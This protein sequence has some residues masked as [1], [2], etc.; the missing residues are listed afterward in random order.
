MLAIAAGLEIP[1]SEIELNAVRAQGAGGQHVNKTSTAVHLRFDALASSLPDPIRERLLAMSDRRISS[2][3]VVVIKAQT[4]RS[5][6]ANRTEAL[7]RLRVLLAAAAVVPV[8]RRATRPTRA[9]RQRRLDAK[10]LQGK[11]KKLRTSIE[12]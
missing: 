6:E 9:S 7:E 4:Q 5:Q 3:G 11:I 10:T 12:D 1:L 8:K 2:Q